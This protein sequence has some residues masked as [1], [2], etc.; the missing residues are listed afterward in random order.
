MESSLLEVV[1]VWAAPGPATRA[2]ASGGSGGRRFRSSPGRHGGEAVAMRRCGRAGGAV[3][4]GHAKRPGRRLALDLDAHRPG[5]AGDD[6]LGGLDRGGVQVRSSK[7]EIS[8]GMMLPACDSVAALYC[9]T[10]SMMLSPCGPS[11][12]PT[13]GAGVAL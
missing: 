6:L 4:T 11:A 9:R 7:I 5:G 8:T 13:G 12:V 10:K 3:S 1:V 2:V